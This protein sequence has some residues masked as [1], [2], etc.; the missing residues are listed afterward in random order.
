MTDGSKT[1]CFYVFFLCIFFYAYCF[2]AHQLSRLVFTRSESA[3][4]D[5]GGRQRR[6]VCRRGKERSSLFIERGVAR[7][8]QFR[9]GSTAR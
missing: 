2:H 7:N 6:D 8:A 1:A 3:S 4:D 9:L 5:D